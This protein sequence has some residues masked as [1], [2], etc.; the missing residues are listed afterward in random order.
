MDRSAYEKQLAARAVSAGA[1]LKTG[2]E[3]GVVAEGESRMQVKGRLFLF[4][5]MTT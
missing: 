3:S 5:R 1:I 2:R 4:V